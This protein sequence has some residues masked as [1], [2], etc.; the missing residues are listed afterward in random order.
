M[1]SSSHPLLS[2]DTGQGVGPATVAQVG[3][4]SPSPNR[5]HG[6]EYDSGFGDLHIWSRENYRLLGRKDEGRRGQQG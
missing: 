2:A 1:E 4:V 5:E 6:E 3:K